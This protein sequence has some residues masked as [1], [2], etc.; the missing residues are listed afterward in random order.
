MKQFESLHAIERERK[1]KWKQI[2][3][4]PLGPICKGVPPSSRRK[5]REVQKSI[6]PSTPSTLPPPKPYPKNITPNALPTQ[7]LSTKN[8]RQMRKLS[9]GKNTLKEMGF[10]KRKKANN[11]S[12]RFFCTTT[13]GIIN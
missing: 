4:F 9:I 12:S 13:C 5:R 11:K 6:D 10:D 1:P 7:S 8:F 3:H 2:R